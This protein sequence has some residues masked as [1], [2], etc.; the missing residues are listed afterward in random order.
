MVIRVYQQVSGVVFNF[1]VNSFKFVDV[2][3][4]F[5]AVGDGTSD[6]KFLVSYFKHKKSTLYAYKNSN[7]YHKC[8]C[9][10]DPQDI[11]SFLFAFMN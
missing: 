7:I 2:F 6:D 11:L 3:V 1:L 8:S 10:V 4:W 9:L 5:V